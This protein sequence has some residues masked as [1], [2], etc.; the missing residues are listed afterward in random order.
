MRLVRRSLVMLA[1]VACSTGC[2]SEDSSQEVSAS[3]CSDEL[4]NDRDGL[5]DCRD[6]DCSAF[7]FC[8]DA[9]ALVPE[10]TSTLCRDSADNDRDGLVDCQDPDCFEFAFCTDAGAPVPENTSALCQDG[11]D[12]D[13]NGAADCRDA[14]CQ[15]FVFCSDA[16]PTSTPERSNAT[17][18]DGLDNDLD[19]DVDCEDVECAGLADC[20]CP[21]RVPVEGVSLAWPLPTSLDLGQGWNTLL[22]SPAGTCVEHEED[23]ASGGRE[24]TFEYYLVEDA[25]S[26]RTRFGLE[27]SAS[28]SGGIYSVDASATYTRDRHVSS[29]STYLVLESRVALPG[30]NVSAPR[31]A[32]EAR[33]LL[34]SNPSAF[35]GA[36]GDHFMAGVRRGA[37]YRAVFRFTGMTARDRRE[38]TTELG[39]SAGRF[40]GDIT[41]QSLLESYASRYETSIQVFRSGG[42]P[43]PFVG[44][45]PE[46]IE[47]ALAFPST[48][49]ESSA[50]PVSMS[51]RSY[52]TLLDFPACVVLPSYRSQLR[53]IDDLAAAAER[54]R[55]VINDIDSRIDLGGRLVQPACSET[56]TALRDRQDALRA[57]LGSLDT[58]YD[59]CVRASPECVLPPAG[60][61]VTM[62][63]IPET[64]GPTC[65]TGEGVSYAFDSL[66]YCTRC[67]W[68]VPGP[69]NLIHGS[70]GFENPCRFMRPNAR[71]LTRFRANPV[72]VQGYD[73]G[74][75]VFSWMELYV[76]ARGEG[77]MSCPHNGT[78][79]SCLFA[80]A[81]GYTY[82]TGVLSNRVRAQSGDATGYVNAAW[83]VTS[84]PRTCVLNNVVMQICDESAD[85]SVG[86][87]PL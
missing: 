9:G 77:S 17:C 1:V 63:S 5:V 23:T 72:F 11:I 65:A 2:S 85:E 15:A 45:V 29:Y 68:S 82:D 55:V 75:S 14:G 49:T 37:V 13:F 54:A 3:D 67:E 41:S 80:N 19:G 31:L 50:V 69:I 46:L 25:S 28:F 35:L 42:V 71:T 60:F 62:P 52:Y 48:V 8:T 76:G 59:A 56:L 40:S 51:T 30:T 66:G 16:G 38:L 32:D 61:D 44:T 79:S 64:C 4:D 78:N 21:E 70:T 6:P 87:Q 34:T 24:E 26:L 10:N 27:A 81:R 86:C 73:P 58:A 36:C 22:T 84:S 53:T 83:C 33:A 7:S 18:R 12:N 43:A 20:E 39:G 57:Y 74:A 47:E